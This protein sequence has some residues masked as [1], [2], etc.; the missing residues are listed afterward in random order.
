MCW[1]K[2]WDS[3]KNWL[4][5]NSLKIKIH[6]ESA[7]NYGRFSNYF[8]PCAKLLVRLKRCSYTFT[9]AQRQLSSTIER[10][11]FAHTHIADHICLNFLFIIPLSYIHYFAQNSSS[12][13]S[14]A[15]ASS[16]S[17]CMA[18]ICCGS[19]V[20]SPVASTGASTRVKALSLLQKECQ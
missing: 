12:S 1:W 9:V 14:W 3:L 6:T 20:T 15:A 10:P 16:A 5:K 2:K 8:S 18:R 13:S 4:E 11:K 19:I 7:K 17:F